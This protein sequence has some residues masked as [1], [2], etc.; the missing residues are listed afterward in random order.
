M[1]IKIK[2]SYT[3][4]GEKR[5]ILKLLRPLLEKGYRCKEQKGTP[6][7]RIYIQHKGHLGGGEDSERYIRIAISLDISMVSWY[8]TP[9]NE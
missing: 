4:E 6:R 3:D 2:V 7:S 8:N 9:I 5:L 1:S